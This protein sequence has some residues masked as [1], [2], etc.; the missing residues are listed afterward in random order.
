MKYEL[1][2]HQVNNL[3]TFLDRCEIKGVKEV[4]AFQ[5]LINIL[6]SPIQEEKEESK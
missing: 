6:N 2:E 4:Q 5:E 1:Q 3:I